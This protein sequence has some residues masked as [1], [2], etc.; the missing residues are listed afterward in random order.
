VSPV[1]IVSNRTEGK[2]EGSMR[3]RAFVSYSKIMKSADNRPRFRRRPVLPEN[4]T[5]CLRDGKYRVRGLPSPAIE[6]EARTIVTDSSIAER[7]AHAGADGG[8]RAP[9][10]NRIV[11]MR[12]GLFGQNY[13]AQFDGVSE[14]GNSS[15]GVIRL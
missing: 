3:I 8:V 12:K 11:Q 14:G 6:R 1:D 4:S 9:S 10:V 5:P 7:A 15:L 2:S 13:D